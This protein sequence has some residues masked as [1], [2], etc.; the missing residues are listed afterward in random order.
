[1]R[2]IEA[3]IGQSSNPFSVG[4]KSGVANSSTANSKSHSIKSHSIKRLANSL[5]PSLWEG[6]KIRLRIRRGG[7]KHFAFCF[8]NSRLPSP[9]YAIIN[10]GEI[11]PPRGRV[12][13]QTSFGAIQT[14]RAA[15]QTSSCLLYTSPSPRDR[16]KTRMPS[17]A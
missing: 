12:T 5:S 4:Q 6:R 11:D 3:T 16:Q 17:S 15:N 13:A 14:S 2:V 7:H 10:D 8:G 1:M 9:T